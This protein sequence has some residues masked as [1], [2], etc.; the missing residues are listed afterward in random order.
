MDEYQKAIAQAMYDIKPSMSG[1]LVLAAKIDALVQA[2]IAEALADRAEPLGAL[3][4][5]DAS[6]EVAPRRPGRPRKVAA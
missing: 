3:D 5:V 4:P 1:A 2:R 6:D